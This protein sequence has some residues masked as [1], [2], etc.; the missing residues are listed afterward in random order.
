[1]SP[2]GELAETL[3]RAA[4]DGSEG[5]DGD[6]EGGGDRAIGEAVEVEHLQ[7][8]AGDGGEAVEEL[9]QAEGLLAA[10]GV[11]GGRGFEGE[12][13]EGGG[14]PASA[15][16]FGAEV[17]EGVADGE[18]AEP[19]PEGAA[20]LEGAEAAEVVLVEAEVEILEDVFDIG[21]GDEGEGTE[22]SKADDA[23]E[24]RGEALD[25]AVPSSG[26]RLEAALE[27]GKVVVARFHA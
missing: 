17:V 18:G 20:G 24:G 11:V 4:D 15:E 16:G 21:L 19:K 5:L 6:A 12:V 8:G 13:V 22:E 9:P 1:M 10:V 26:V 27:E 25:E 3:A 14:L 7:G 2:A 23:F